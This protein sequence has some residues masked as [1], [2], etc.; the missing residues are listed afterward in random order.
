K[1]NDRASS[2]ARGDVELEV[3]MAVKATAN[4]VNDVRADLETMKAQGV[5]KSYR[6]LD[7]NAAL[8]VFKDL[9]K[10]Q[11]DITSSVRP[12]DLP[13]SFRVNPRDEK[14]LDN[15]AAHFDAVSGVDVV[16]TP[17]KFVKAYFKRVDQARNF[18]IIGA[19]ALTVAA[20]FLVV[21]TVRLATYARRREIEVMKLV[22]AS[23]LFVRIPFLAEGAVQG[24]I[25]GG[26]A[27][28]LT[29]VALDVF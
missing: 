27:F 5:V 12:Q 23:N 24:V 6:F 18:I 26:I 13:E 28:G 21:T 16:N 20:A 7:H 1:G 25:G 22:G 4:Q 15:I 14:Q 3:F 10:D 9:Y 2:K 17:A 29:F 19:I 11:K 8:A